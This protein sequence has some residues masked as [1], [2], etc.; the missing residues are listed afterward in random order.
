MSARTAALLAWSAMKAI[1]ALP[2][3]EIRIAPDLGFEENRGQAPAG[4]LYLARFGLNLTAAGFTIAPDVIALEFVG[5]NAAPVVSPSDTIPGVVNVVSGSDPGKWI[6]GIRQFR[7]VRVAQVYRGIDAEYSIDR[8]AV[9]LRYFISAGADT[10]V[11]RWRV[12]G[13]TAELSA[14]RNLLLRAARRRLFEFPPPV[15]SNGASVT[16]RI[17]DAGE[18]GIEMTGG[19]ST[20]AFTLSIPFP[21]LRGRRSEQT[22]LTDRSGGLYA[23]GNVT[24]PVFRTVEYLALTAPQDGICGGSSLYGP[25]P[26]LD[27]FVEKYSAAGA[28]EYVTYV[29]GNGDDSV[30][31]VRSDGRGGLW[32]VGPTGSDDFPVTADALQPRAGG[33]SLFFAPC[34]SETYADLFVMKLQVSSGLPV[35]ATYLG[36]PH[37]DGFSELLVDSGGNA[38]V[39]GFMRDG[40]A[41]SAGAFI[42]TPCD[43]C[44]FAAK[45]NSETRLVYF[46]YLPAQP[47]SY[48]VDSAG[49]LYFA[50]HSTGDF[51]ATSGALQTSYGGGS[52]TR[53]LL[54]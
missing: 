24:A 42:V 29:S 23:V 52:M 1:A 22:F 16:W 12:I 33:S 53:R 46:T 31:E 48:A 37:R 26:C 8:S 25:M 30:V 39:T 34:C 49:A 11:M 20:T 4:I 41:G 36:G 27:A 6:S 40:R 10:S 50:G 32:I 43:G 14:E 18:V 13:G 15:A 45:F 17:S 47:R 9:Q 28:L 35:Y 38:Y 5:S 19:N 3:D 54:S 21:R 44:P 7:N 2:R 51:P